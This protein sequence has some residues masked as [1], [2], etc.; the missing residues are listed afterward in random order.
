M[1]WLEQK[2]RRS[3]CQD[4]SA[5]W[6]KLKPRPQSALNFEL[7][8]IA[9]R[10][11]D[12]NTSK[13]RPRNISSR[14]AKMTK[15]NTNLSSSRR[16]SRKAHF[17]AP[18]SVRRVIMSAPLSKGLFNATYLLQSRRE[19]MLTLRRA[20]RKAQRMSIASPRHLMSLRLRKERSA[21]RTHMTIP[22]TP[23]TR[24]APCPSAKT[25]K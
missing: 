12:D 10:S 15:I 21:L 7:Q 4:F 8:H 22:L 17:S 11:G 25:T 24:S 19:N 3:S 20:E 23:A 14:R 16:K 13:P 5:V 9:K 2:R 18:S 1:E 6:P